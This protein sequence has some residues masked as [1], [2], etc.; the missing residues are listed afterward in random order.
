MSSVRT[1]ICL[2][3][4]A[5]AAALA[6]AAAP[7]R[8]DE[9]LADVVAKVNPKLVKLYGYGGYRGLAD[10]G[11]A[12][13]ISRDG[14]LLTVNNH[15]I[16]GQELKV[17]LADGRKFNAKRVAA[18]PQLD[19]ALLQIVDDKGQPL[20]EDLPCFDVSA[21]ARRPRAETGTPILAFSNQFKI[22]SRDEPM[23][24]QRGVIAACAKLPLR[25]GVHEVP[26]K[27]EVYVIDAITNNPGAAGGVITT[28]KGELLGLIGKELQN[29]LTDTWIN[30][31]IPVQATA[32]GLRGDKKVTVSILE[33]IEKKEKYEATP[34]K[35]K[36]EGALAFHGIILVPNVVERTPPYV[37]DT[38]PNSPAA[39]AGVK[40]DDLIVYVN[41][42]QVGNIAAFRE[43]MDD[44]PPGTEVKIEVRRGD[45]LQTLTLKLA[46][47]VVKGPV[48]PK[49]Q[50]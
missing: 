1:R 19:V 3:A 21:A 29:N 34:P 22:A 28:R 6:L 27:G 47:P 48:A 49:K 30:Y 10:Y 4:A 26:Y 18:E 24:V 17:H 33:V 50:P 40:P 8:A 46:E 7:A 13:I 42:I 32:E 15:L 9:S 16:D 23:S 44:F 25:R 2:L 38:Y 5:A 43:I 45:K 36:R 14:Y 35:P 41:G 39:K 20:K 37:E 31:A 12:A 11:T